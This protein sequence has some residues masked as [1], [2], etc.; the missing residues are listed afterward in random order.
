MSRQIDCGPGAGSP[1][2]TKVHE[3]SGLE[4]YQTGVRQARARVTECRDDIEERE[5][6]GRDVLV[7]SVKDVVVVSTSGRNVRRHNHKAGQLEEQKVLIGSELLDLHT[8]RR[9]GV[10]SQ[11]RR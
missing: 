3:I 8:Y 6:S 11:Q 7:L 2:L 1:R 4:G 10:G 9:H 5:P